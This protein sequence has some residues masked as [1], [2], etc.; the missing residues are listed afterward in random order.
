MPLF[1]KR[2]WAEISLERIAANVK[3]VRRRIGQQTDIIAVVKANAYGHGTSGCAAHLRRCGVTSF[4]VATLD[5]A[6]V[7]REAVKDAGILVLTGCD[8]GQEPLFQEH[9]LT[10]SVFERGQVPHVTIELKID[11]GMGRLGVPHAQAADFLEELSGRVSGVFSQFASSDSDPEFT[12]EQL[13]NFLAATKRFTCRRHVANSAALRFPAAHLDAVR[14]GLALYGVAPCPEVSDVLP[15][16]AWKTRVLSL[17]AM[18]PGETVGYGRT[19]KLSRPSLVAVLPV[20]YADGY[21][22]GFSNSGQ[23]RIR[24]ALAPLIGRV[25]MDLISVDVTEIPGVSVGDEVT[26]LEADPASPISAARLA[27]RLGTIPYE[28]L[29]SIGSRVERVYV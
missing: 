29:T 13:A 19:F 24:G 14:I 17:R 12:A 7:V 27:K 23:V 5:E 16:L 15:A 3:A 8:T 25:S 22:R 9:R 18:S 28:I 2:S 6:L 4:A 21:S 26:L 10:A 11:S 20:G 1:G